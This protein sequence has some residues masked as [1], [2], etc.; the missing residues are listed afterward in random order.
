VPG[1]LT[2]GAGCSQVANANQSVSAPFAGSQADDVAFVATCNLTGV[3]GLRGTLGATNHRQLWRSTLNM[4]TRIATATGPSTGGTPDRGDVIITGPA[5][6]TIDAGGL[7]DVINAGGAP[8][9]GQEAFPGT[10]GEFQDPNRNTIN[11]GAGNDTIHLD[12][13]GG[14]GTGRD[15]V[16]GGAGVDT[17]TYALRFGTVGF[18]GQAGVVVSLNDVADD[19][20][21]G[22]DQPD[23]LA[24]G[25]GDNVKADVENVTGTKRDDTLT[26]GSSSNRLE[27]GEGKDTL[28]GL[29]GVDVLL[30]RE[31]GLSGLRDTL[32]CGLPAPSVAPQTFMGFPIG[33]TS[34]GDALDADLA[35]LPPKDCETVTQG[36]VREGPNVVI[37]ST[38]RRAARGR[39][40]VR[41]R[42]PR[43]AGRTCAGTL[44]LAARTGRGGPKTRFSIRRGRGGAATVAPPAGAVI[45]A[46]GRRPTVR[47]VAVE[48]GRHGPV[49]TVAYARVST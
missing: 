21:P 32:A 24:A 16:S 45:P 8:Y 46:G 28:T 29:S 35:D 6:D 10:T 17:A 49:T 2:A 18:P 27:G 11:A 42:C 5:G 9:K 23:S 48:R 31:P 44:R 13:Q 14:G 15:T 12:A 22:I 33:G 40:S 39:L 47:L 20:D 43:S 38:A 30:A 25:E 3:V 36:A 4:P 1:D 26:G 37:A 19:G 7:D 34:T 41:L